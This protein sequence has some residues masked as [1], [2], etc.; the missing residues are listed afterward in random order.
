MMPMTNLTPFPAPSTT[1]M[2]PAVDVTGEAHEPL[3]SADLPRRIRVEQAIL[4]NPWIERL[5]RTAFAAS[6]GL[7]QG[8]VSYTH[9]TLPTSDL[10]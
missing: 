3:A 5:G 1:D 10:V 8:P 4:T 6:M 9:L 2:P 7:V